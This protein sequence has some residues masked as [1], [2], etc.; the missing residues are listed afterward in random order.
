MRRWTMMR[1]SVGVALVAGLGAGACSGGTEPQVN[2]PLCATGQYSCGDER[3]VERCND[4]QTGWAHEKDC[5]EGSRCVEGKSECQC[6]HA[7]QAP[8]AESRCEDGVCRIVQC[9]EGYSDCDGD[10]DTGCEAHTAD[11]V[12]NCG[13]CN[14]ACSDNHG[15]PTCSQ[16]NCSIAK[17]DDGFADCN[18]DAYDG[19]EVDLG[20]DTEHCGACEEVCSDSHGTT[21]CAD[22]SCQVKCDEG[23]EDCDE[24]QSCETPTDN[25]TNNC[26][27]CGEVCSSYHGTPKCVAGVCDIA[28]DPSYGDCNGNADDGCEA[29]LGADTDHCGACDASCEAGE[30]CYQ[31]GCVQCAAGLPCTPPNKPC[32]AGQWNCTGQPACEDT[33]VHVQDGNECGVNQVCHDGECVVCV[34]G[35]SCVPSECRAGQTDCGTGEQLCLESGNAPNGTSCGQGDYVCNEG[36]CVPCVAGID[37]EPDGEPCHHGSWDCASLSCADTG[38]P[39]QNGL[40]CG[41]NQVCYQGDCVVC[42][43]GESCTPGNPC[44]EGETDCGTGTSLCADTGTPKPNGTACGSGKVCNDG[45]CIGCIPG[46]QC[47]PA[48]P[49]HVGQLDCTASP[50]ACVDQN[51]NQPDGT[52]CGTDRV[53]F[54]GTCEL[55]VEGVACEPANPCHL[56]VSDCGTGQST[57][58]DSGTNKPDGTT[59][60]QGV[61]SAGS[62]VE[63]IGDVDC[64]ECQV[65]SGNTC[66]AGDEGQACSDDG[67]LCTVDVCGSGICTHTAKDCAIAHGSA[68][69]NPASGQ[70]EVVSCDIGYEPNTAGDDCVS[71]CGNGTCES[72]HLET[73]D[74]CQEDCGWSELALGYYH[75]CGIKN[76]GTVWCWGAGGSGQLGNG[77]TLDRSVPTRI[78]GLAGATTVASGNMTVCA[79]LGGDGSV[80]CWGVADFGAL[81]DDQT[82]TACGGSDCSYVPVQAGNLTNVTEIA[83]GGAFSCAVT[84]GGRLYC[85]GENNRGQLGLS[86]TT[87]RTLPTQVANGTVGV[88]ASGG[89]S[90]MCFELQ[91]GEYRCS[92][93]NQLGQ[94][95]IGTVAD[96]VSSPVTSPAMGTAADARLGSSFTCLRHTNETVACAGSN[97]QGTLGLGSSSGPDAC[98]IGSGE[99]VGCST[100]FVVVPNVSPV[101]SVATGWVNACAVEKTTGEV[102]CWGN[103]GRGQLGR[104]HNTGSSS[105]TG[106]TNGN[107]WEAVCSATPEKVLDSIGNNA[108][109]GVRHVYPGLIHVCAIAEDGHAWCWGDGGAG[110][111]GNGDTQDSFLPVRVS[112]P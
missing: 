94:F 63:C 8:N 82:H 21:F 5:P 41:S 28:C 35:Q 78:T 39:R 32:H 18:D 6:M 88:R 2:P 75:A 65:C 74:S 7:C 52:D 46:D 92:G 3:T 71:R 34:A 106:S 81:G 11:D 9:Q 43:E 85:W 51:L 54:Q 19:C 55:C 20:S 60:P 109:S 4:T 57:C 29:S 33:N 107:P 79:L 59:C 31:G 93:T 98:Q 101:S 50:P 56:G 61:C 23:W 53:C 102:W 72:A 42:I 99:Y 10:P 37:C 96:V 95:G 105:C 86:D 48:N 15:T 111:L 25:D 90:F 108:L 38:N 22:G 40:S 100:D 80:W 1:V 64:G 26:G 103:N 49:C 70:C 67:D 24:N 104:G 44:H 76:D 69:C 87:N 110:R 89:S 30:V 47:V 27:G 45:G 97:R 36:S 112:E 16:G 73:I 77:Q 91:T 13:N 12:E 62:C 14:V 66:V 58:S 84:S 17:C 68:Q 83:S